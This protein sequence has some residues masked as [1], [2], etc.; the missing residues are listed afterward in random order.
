VKFRSNKDFASRIQKGW[1]V[2][3]IYYSRTDVISLYIAALILHPA[4]RTKYIKINWPAKWVKPNLKKV[5]KFWEDYREK[6][7]V[8]SLAISYDEV[9]RK[10][11]EEKEFDTFKRIG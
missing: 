6:A 1:D 9:Q 8:S 5:E 10:S 2:F 11:E 3:D 4:R 7:F